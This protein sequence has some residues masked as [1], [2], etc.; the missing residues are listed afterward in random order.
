LIDL[1]S[2]LP[3]FLQ[4]LKIENGLS[5]NTCAAYRSDVLSFL[6]LLSVAETV[7]A[8]DIR[9]YVRYLGAQGYAPASVQRKI[10]A[11]KRFCRYLY[12]QGVL[13]SDISVEIVVRA[14]PRALPVGVFEPVMRELLAQPDA[15]DRY[16]QRDHAL[17]SLMYG[18]GL[19]VSEICALKLSQIGLGE[20]W[21][22]V[23][24][25]GNKERL[26]PIPDSVSKILQAYIQTSR[27][28]IRLA[29]RVAWVFLSRGG[30][31]MSRQAVF[32]I[33]RKYAAR[34]GVSDM[35][36]HQLRHAFATHLLNRDANVRDVQVCLGHARLSTTQKYLSVSTAH[37][38]RMYDNAHPLSS[39]DEGSGLGPERN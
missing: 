36:P 37:M 11:T 22:R 26:V 38:R 17:L 18:A 32:Q 13:S 4:V 35:H 16:Q 27:G 12:I 28:E 6:G 10:A 8:D 15:T 20:S 19:R 25:K 33:V 21:I 34:M 24:G 7:T 5:E 29:D 30:Q 3:G 31:A 2:Y 9:A 39:A 14:T 1:F 23:V